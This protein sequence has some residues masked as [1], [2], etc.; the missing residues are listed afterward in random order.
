MMWFNVIL[1]LLQNKSR[2]VGEEEDDDKA[3]STS[4]RSAHAERRRKLRGDGGAAAGELADNAAANATLQ[5][6]LDE[7]SDTMFCFVTRT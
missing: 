5:R 4:P 2:G 1:F 3:T 7:V 6:E